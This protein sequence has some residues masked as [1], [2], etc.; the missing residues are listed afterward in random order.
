MMRCALALCLLVAC[1]P[2]SLESG[3]DGGLI[4]L[5]DA[6]APVCPP[7][8]APAGPPACALL[9][10]REGFCRP[11]PA[12]CAPDERADIAR[13]CVSVGAPCTGSLKDEGRCRPTRDRVPPGH[14]LDLVMGWAPV[15]PTGCAAPFVDAKGDCRPDGAVCPL[16]GFATPSGCVDHE[17]VCD[18]WPPSGVDGIHVRADAPEGGDGTAQRPLRTVEEALRHGRPILIDSGRYVLPRLRQS[19]TL[20]GRCPSQVTFHDPEP[21]G[22][23]ITLSPPS[24]DTTV[25]VARV[26]FEDAAI[27]ASVFS[28][29][30]ELDYVRMTGVEVGVVVARGS[31]HVRDSLFERLHR[32]DG[33]LPSGQAVQL[34]PGS[35]AHLLRSAI[36]EAE[37]TALLALGATL[38]LD[39][40]L[41]AHGN[42]AAIFGLDGARVTATDLVVVDQVRP[43]VLAVAGG[44][45]IEL[46]NT[47]I[48]QTRSEV[49]PRHPQAA[50]DG[51]DGAHLLIEDTVVRDNDHAGVRV[52]EG[53]TAEVR[54]SLVVDQT[55]VGPLEAAGVPS[56]IGLFISGGAHLVL[57]DTT[58]AGHRAVALAILGQGEATLLR[59][60]LIDD[61]DAE[62]ERS[63]GR[64]LVFAQAA[65]TL[66]IEDS[67]LAPSTGRALTSIGSE[68]L[69][70]MGTTIDMRDLDDPAAIALLAQDTDTTINGM[71]LRLV[72]GTA[73]LLEG[74]IVRIEGTRIVGP[75]C[76]GALN[77]STVL[78]TGPEIILLNTAIE[79]ACLAALNFTT[80]DDQ[81]R[82][83]ALLQGVLIAG[84]EVAGDWPLATSLLAVASDVRIVAS[85]LRGMQGLGLLHIGSDNSSIEVSDTSIADIHLG[86]QGDLGWGV[87]LDEGAHLTAR[88]LEIGDTRVAGIVAQDSTLL[89]ENLHIHDVHSGLY[90]I[91]SD[92]VIREGGGDALHLNGSEVHVTQA[93]LERAARYGVF[94]QDTQGELTCSTV[95][96]NEWARHVSQPEGRRLN[97]VDVDQEGNRMGRLEPGE[98]TDV[99]PV[100]RP[101]RLPREP[102]PD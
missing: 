89:M 83:D 48:T 14:R 32:N 93:L 44:T 34:K 78:Y 46:H 96:G 62:P 19:T 43:A 3:Q 26:A 51:E 49:T 90:R 30:L 16:G 45:Q 11:D 22:A 99:G 47:L 5:F 52:I 4:V 75:G 84:V 64:A 100:G 17:H 54:R 80:L 60:L 74:G 77:V 101:E 94:E 7:Q 37:G 63:D 65:G 67:W 76:A 18:D 42:D 39:D 24:P 50:I 58:V 82:T 9:F 57:E 95:R 73:L 29:R 25:R 86:P 31:V 97:W 92:A 69:S 88:G 72:T 41:V 12:L 102:N 33:P 23:A 1:D 70:L 2:P 59:S 79:G 10:V 8:A 61:E 98:S 6:G 35:E 36:L 20:I 68:Q 40:V 21:R 15:G 71:L 13:G 87:F 28:G 53:A 66:T 27:G 85:V 55:S 38:S 81:P 56:G 91:E